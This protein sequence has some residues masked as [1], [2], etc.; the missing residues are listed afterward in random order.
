MSYYASLVAAS[1]SLLVL[2]SG[3][4]VAVGLAA[5]SGKIATGGVTAV[6]VALSGFLSATLWTHIGWLHGS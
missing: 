5:T 2:A 1:V 3:G 4:T 6:G